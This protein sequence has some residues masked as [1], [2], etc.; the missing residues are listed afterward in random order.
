VSPAADFLA[1]IDQVYNLAKS[2]GKGDPNRLVTDY[3]RQKRYAGRDGKDLIG[4]VDWSFI[5]SAP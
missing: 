3:Y 4:E 5:D 2:Y 1:N